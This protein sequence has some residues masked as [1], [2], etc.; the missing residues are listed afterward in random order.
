MVT[1]C[2]CCWRTMAGYQVA[3]ALAA[4]RGHQHQRVAA[5]N[6]MLDDRLLRAAELF[7]AKDVLQDGVGGRQSGGQAGRQA[8]TLK[9]IADGACISS[10]R[11]QFDQ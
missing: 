7:V 3:Q 2:P 11:G 10:A 1:P 6:H 8:D 5:A 9:L 4:A